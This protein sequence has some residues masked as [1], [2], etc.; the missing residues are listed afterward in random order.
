MPEVSKNSG[1]PL[2]VKIQPEITTSPDAAKYILPSNPKPLPLW[3][4]V[5]AVGIVVLIAVVVVGG[6]LGWF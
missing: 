2:K 3:L 5:V 4:K 1:I 6:R